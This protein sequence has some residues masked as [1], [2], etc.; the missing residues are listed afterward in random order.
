MDVAADSREYGGRIQQWY[1]NGLGPQ[2]F[3]FTAYGDGYYSLKGQNSQLCVEVTKNSFEPGTKIQQFACQDGGWQRWRFVNVGRN[4]YK[5]IGQ[6]S[7][8]CLDVAA[9][10]HHRRHRP[11]N[12]VLQ[13]PPPP[14]L[15]TR[16]PLSGT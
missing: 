1:C 10:L 2:N 8:H 15:E 6:N 16:T 12:L 5:A 4:Y 11:A 9:W 7:Q 14:D 3:Q 13:Q